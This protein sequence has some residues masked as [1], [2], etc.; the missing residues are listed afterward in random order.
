METRGDGDWWSALAGELARVFPPSQTSVKLRR[1]C[2]RQCARHADCTHRSSTPNKQPSS[3]RSEYLCV[4]TKVILARHGLHAP[5]LRKARA[6]TH[7]EKQTLR[8]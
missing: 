8:H 7:R 3:R 2:S 6:T 5:S 1:G 4:A